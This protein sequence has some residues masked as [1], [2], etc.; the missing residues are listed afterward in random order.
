[1]GSDPAPFFANL[2]LYY[3][4][5]ILKLKKVDLR[6]A[7]QFAKVFCFIDDLLVLNDNL[8]FEKNYHEIYPPEL[9]LK[10]ENI[11]NF[12]G[13]FLDLSITIHNNKF[14]T[15]LYDKRDDFRFSIVR[16]P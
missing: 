14:T 5:W 9:E 1:M 13:S 2:F 15:S 6:R 10:K 11:D 3:N 16:M 12:K 7:T 4:K 8:E